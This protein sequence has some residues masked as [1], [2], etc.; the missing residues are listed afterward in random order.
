MSQSVFQ[1]GRFAFPPPPGAGAA[2]LPQVLAATHSRPLF[3]ITLLDRTPA[4][5]V[6]GNRTQVR[7]AGGT[8]R[9]DMA[10]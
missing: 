3:S 1:S 9:V 4:C 7:G 5:F 8:E 2:H 10:H 6:T